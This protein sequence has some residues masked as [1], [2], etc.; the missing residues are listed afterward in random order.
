MEGRETPAGAIADA[1]T[2]GNH[3]DHGRRCGSSGQVFNFYGVP[4]VGEPHF[5]T[6][7]QVSSLLAAA[8][9]V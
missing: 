3:T 1:R 9:G 5:K 6:I 8:G 4:P 2:A 7:E